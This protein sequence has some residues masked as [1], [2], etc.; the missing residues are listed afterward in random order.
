MK[1]ILQEIWWLHQGEE[2]R[3]TIAPCPG[4]SL[5]T[6]RKGAVGKRGID[7]GIYPLFGANLLIG[8]V[9]DR[10]VN[11]YDRRLPNGQEYL[12]ADFPVDLLLVHAD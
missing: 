1:A 9:P 10:R 4:S 7:S 3:H 11:M 8:E 12:P 6:N 2:V 5:K